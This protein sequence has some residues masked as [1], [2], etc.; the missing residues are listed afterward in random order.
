MIRFLSARAHGKAAY[1]SS[2]ARQ[3]SNAHLGRE[4]REEEGGKKRR[5]GRRRGG[6]GGRG[7]K[8]EE[9]LTG[10]N[11]CH[12]G[13]QSRL[14]LKHLPMGSSQHSSHVRRENRVK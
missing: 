6:R 2:C 5:E 8:G 9:D 7:G 12:L 1:N 3:N 13:E 14:N 10:P 11:L 4:G